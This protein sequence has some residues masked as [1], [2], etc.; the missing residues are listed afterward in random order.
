MAHVYALKDLEAR[1]AMIP[2]RKAVLVKI[3]RKNVIVKMEVC[4]PA[5]L[6]NATAHLDGLECTATDL[7]VI[8]NMASIVLMIAFVKITLLVIQ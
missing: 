6:D 8:T 5:T 1:I 4:V 7:V 2:V 3:A